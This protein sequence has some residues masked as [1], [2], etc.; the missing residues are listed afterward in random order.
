MIPKPFQ[1]W[2][3]GD[4]P[5]AGHMIF[6]GSAEEAAQLGAAKLLE[7]E[8][9]LEH[10]DVFV[11]AQDAPARRFTILV[12]VTRARIDEEAGTVTPERFAFIP[13]H[14]DEP[15]ASIQAS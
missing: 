1:V 8:D 11:W 6:A 9:P 10:F 3:A 4:D 7:P 12:D 5:D 2:F 15:E 14:F 13:C